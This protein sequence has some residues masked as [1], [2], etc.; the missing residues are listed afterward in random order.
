MPTAK[1]LQNAKKKLKM[2]PKPNGN[3]PKL[4]NRLTYILIGVDPKMKRD[5]EFLKAVREYAKSRP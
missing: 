2:T 5:R 3:K 1:Q 4:P